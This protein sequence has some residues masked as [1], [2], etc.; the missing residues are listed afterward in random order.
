MD[1]ETI[2][3]DAFGKSLSGLGVNLLVKDVRRLAGFLT[4]VLE[5]RAHRLTEDFAIMTYHGDVFQ[6]HADHTYHSHPLPSLLPESGARGAGIEIRLYETDPDRAVE[7]AAASDHG[8]TVLKAPENQ[9]HG[10]R[11]CVLL[12]ENGYAWLP[13]RRLSDQEMD[14]L[15]AAREM[16][17]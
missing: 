5:A 10:L 2:S 8:V 7:R 14:T 17:D 1:Y 15:R 11:E 12:C 9:M 13:S 16:A 6:L 4:T 3:A